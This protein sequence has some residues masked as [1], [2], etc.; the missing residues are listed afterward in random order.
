VPPKVYIETTIPSFYYSERKDAEMTACRDWTREW[1]K[2][3]STNFVLVTSLAVM[4]ELSR[5]AQTKK[6]EKLELISSLRN[7]DIN[8]EIIDIAEIYIKRFVMPND[9]SGD[10][11]HLAVASYYKCDVLLTW[12]CRHLANYQKAKHIKRV[13]ALLGLSTPALLTPL[14]LMGD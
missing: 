12:N 4:N 14:E 6:K 5:G 9:I 2:K 1:W 8:Q 7:L 13:N 11:L 3:S 10:A